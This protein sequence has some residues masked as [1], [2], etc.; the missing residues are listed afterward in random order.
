MH[1]IEEKE[2]LYSQYDRDTQELSLVEPSAVHFKIVVNNYKQ[3]DEKL[4]K[5]PDDDIGATMILRHHGLPPQPS[6]YLKYPKYDW[7]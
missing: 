4:L 5:G 2:N 6:K 1:A 3:R 7:F